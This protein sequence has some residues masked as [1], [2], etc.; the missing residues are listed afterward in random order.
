MTTKHSSFTRFIILIDWATQSY[1]NENELDSEYKDVKRQI[2]KTP[3]GKSNKKSLLEIL[4]RQYLEQKKIVVS[5]RVILSID[6]DKGNSK[7]R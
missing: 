3:L 6:L 1:R 4:E 5:E 7:E 2:R